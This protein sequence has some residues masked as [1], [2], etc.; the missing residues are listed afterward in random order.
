[1]P[2]KHAESAGV[3]DLTKSR[4]ENAVSLQIRN[5][6]VLASMRREAIQ[7]NEDMIA[8]NAEV[9]EIPG[10]GLPETGGFERYLRKTALL[11]V[12]GIVAESDFIRFT[13]L[14]REAKSLYEGFVQ[15]EKCAG[16]PPAEEAETG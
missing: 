3:Y 7:R 10:D 12:A 5:H 13:G 6:H 1:M 2:T 8:Q 14:L 11:Y 15:K 4:E 9:P 16:E